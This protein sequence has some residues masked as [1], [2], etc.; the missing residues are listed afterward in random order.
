[1]TKWQEIWNKRGGVDRPAADLQA[2]IDLDGFDGGAGKV[3]APDWRV[4]AQAVARALLMRPGDSLF[5]V[6]CGAGAF[7]YALRDAGFHIAGGI[8]YSEGL[9][10]V[11][12][13]HFPEASLNRAEASALEIHPHCDYV[14][15]NSVF[16]YFPSFEYAAVVLARMCAK[17][18]KG[19]AVLEIPDQASNVES[20][21]ARRDLLSEEEYARK[22][23]GLEHRYYPRQWFADRAAELGLKCE[24]SDQFLPNYAQ[25]RFRFNCIIRKDDD[26][27]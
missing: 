6:G 3:H 25:S 7:L 9:I 1:M 13:A 19:I 26:H 24:T 5:E 4:Y 12:C 22:Y 11:A 23:A 8:D 21:R 27:A 20:E 10:Q 15:A 14:V 17:A 2:L 18:R 16:H